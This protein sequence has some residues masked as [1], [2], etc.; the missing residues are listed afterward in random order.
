[1]Q[2]LENPD[3]GRIE[4]S[5][6]QGSEVAFVDG[7][8]SS[9]KAVHGIDLLKECIFWLKRAKVALEGLDDKI[10]GRGGPEGA[11]QFEARSL[12]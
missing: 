7:T 5:V 8:R 12:E 9:K 1:M 6:I 2:T 3:I 4:E 11:D 10:W